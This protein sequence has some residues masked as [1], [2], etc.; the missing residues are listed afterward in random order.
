MEQLINLKVNI[1][2]KNAY[3]YDILIGNNLLKDAES[4]IKKYSSAN[5]FLIITNETVA[6]LYQN[7]LNITNAN[8]FIL[9]DGEEYKNFESYKSI[10]DKAIDIK[11]ERKDCIIAFGGG[12]VGDIA[13]FVAATYMRGC[14]FIQ[15]PTT[16][17][18][19]VDS[20]VG[21]KVAINHEH[22][23]NL[24]GNFYQPKLVLTDISVLKTLDLRQLKT[25]LAEVLKYAY[26]EKSSGSELNYRLLE[27]LEQN[28]NDIFNLNPYVLAQVINICCSIKA[29]V[30]NQD[31]TEK[32]LRAIL[33]L[34]HTFAH[35]IENL[36]NYK[37]YTHGEAV[38]IGIKMAFDLSL[39]KN[40]VTQ[41]YFDRATSLLD[42]YEIIPQIKEFDKEKFY[43][44]MFLDKKAQNNKIRF[45]L[46]CTDSVVKI[47]S[48]VTKEELFN[49]F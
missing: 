46:P 27:F 7:D 8:W 21:G 44:E 12:V 20:S 16:L 1:S 9:K 42:N 32:G 25:G 23:K 36:T 22:G 15:I 35:S 33:N 6:K 29:C 48:D 19:Q 17:L 2:E 37:T 24:I 34:G 49:L 30:V 47:T 41:E 11:L 14:D 31:E 40:F 10:I 5:K 3:S 38:A 4:Y 45:V 28:K 43:N 26:L 18:A 39:N 13:G